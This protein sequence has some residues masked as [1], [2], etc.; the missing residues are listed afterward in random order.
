MV[1]D[2]EI[3]NPDGLFLVMVTNATSRIFFVLAVVMGS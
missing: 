1:A 3:W 2:D